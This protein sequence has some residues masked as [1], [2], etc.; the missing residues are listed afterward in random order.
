MTTETLS[1]K[2]AA[3]KLTCVYCVIWHRRVPVVT[4]PCRMFSLI[5]VYRRPCKGKLSKNSKTTILPHFQFLGQLAPVP[6]SFPIRAKVCMRVLYIPCQISSTSRFIISRL[7]SEKNWPYF[8]LQHSLTRQLTMQRRSWTRVTTTNLPLSSDT[9][10][11]SI[12]QRLHMAKSLAQTLP[13]KSVTDKIMKIITQ[14][15]QTFFVSR[16]QSARSH[17]HQTR[18]GD[19][20]VLYHFCTSKTS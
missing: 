4:L 3:P 19:G 2:T 11:V 8:Q 7:R 16:L 14:K 6:T 1:L 12:S 17:P 18:H 10:I 9:I 13:I 20:G 15:H 5:G